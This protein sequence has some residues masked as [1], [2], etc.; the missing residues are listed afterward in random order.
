MGSVCTLEEGM[1]REVS[2]QVLQGGGEC[3]PDQKEVTAT[4]QPA[5]GLVVDPAEE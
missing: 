4:A 3:S 5:R 2:Q 1:D